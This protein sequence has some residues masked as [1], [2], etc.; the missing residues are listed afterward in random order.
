MQQFRLGDCTSSRLRHEGLLVPSNILSASTFPLS[1]TARLSPCPVNLRRAA[2]VREEKQRETKQ[3]SAPQFP[4]NALSHSTLAHQ[5]SSVSYTVLQF[6]SP[7][8]S[9]AR[10]TQPPPMYHSHFPA[11]SCL[12]C[13][14]LFREISCNSQKASR[15][16]CFLAK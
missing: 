11:I 13:S 6:L 14:H 16:L 1:P 9:Y 4:N 12:S 8:K 15:D 10:L 3:A 7:F 2:A 5:Q